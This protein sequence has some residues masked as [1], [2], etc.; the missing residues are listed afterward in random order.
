MVLAVWTE[1]ANSP[2]H[3][4]LFDAMGTT[5][6]V[7]IKPPAWSLPDERQLRT[8]VSS[9]GFVNV[10]TSVKFLSAKFPSARRFVEIIMEGSSKITR[11]MLAQLPNER[12]TAFIDDVA[13]RL[14]SY[15]I[16]T[17]LE[18]PMESRLLAGRRG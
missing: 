2:A 4:I 9:A 12:K 1:L 13:A 16:D 11:Q 6:G 17:A 10:E 8:L 5:L 18:I 7:D 14:R 15:E 3:A